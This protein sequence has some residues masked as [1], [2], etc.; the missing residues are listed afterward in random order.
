MIISGPQ[1]VSGQT[2]PEADIVDLAPTIL[3]MLGEKV[4]RI[5]DGHVLSEALI[6]PGDV[7]F[8]DD[9]EHLDGSRS[10]ALS[11]DEEAQIEDRLRSLGYL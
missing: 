10:Q 5:M 9:E 6:T 2:L 1:V 7:R 3:H 8:V 4:P 11:A